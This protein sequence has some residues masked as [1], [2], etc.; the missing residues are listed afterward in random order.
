MEKN[1]ALVIV[2]MLNDFVLEGAP[3]EVTG[4][5][6][7]IKPIQR[8]INSAHAQ[9]FP[10]V[11]I[12]DSHDEDDREFN[13]YPP[14]A[15]SG[16]E[17]A[18]VVDSLKPRRQ[19]IIVYKKTLSGFYKT[20]LE[21][22]L[23]KNSIEEIYI[24]GCVV[25]ICVFLIAAEAVARGFSVNVIKDAVAGFCKQDYDFSLEQLNKYFKVNLI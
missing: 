21:E 8:E 19:D 7:I 1:S 13:L 6:E 5:E 4:I 22:I 16:S 20:G 12:C 17:G 15:M 14:H 10:V 25:N 9:G 24:T 3:L 23:K 18:M 11:Y 2:D